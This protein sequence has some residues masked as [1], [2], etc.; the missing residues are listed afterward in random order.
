MVPFIV[1]ITSIEMPVFS[2]LPPHCLSRSCVMAFQLLA[3]FA[4]YKS[5]SGLSQPY[6]GAMIVGMTR[7]TPSTSISCLSSCTYLIHT[8]TNAPGGILPT[9]V[10]NTS[11][12]FCSRSAACLPAALASA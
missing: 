8:T 3:Q 5:L 12:V 4:A 10:V 7:R 1:A 9:L 11:P 6:F 2:G